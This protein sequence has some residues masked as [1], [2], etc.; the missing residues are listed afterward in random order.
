M[1]VWIAYCLPAY[2]TIQLIFATIHSPT[3]L[4]GIVGARAQYHILGFGLHSG[5]LTSPRRG[6]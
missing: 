1:S 4:F 2:F 3:A 6:K 5:Q